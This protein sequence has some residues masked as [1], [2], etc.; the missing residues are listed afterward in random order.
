MQFHRVHGCFNLRGVTNSKGSG[1]KNLVELAGF[2][3][4]PM[5]WERLSV[6]GSAVVKNIGS[7]QSQSR[8]LPKE[9]NK[10]RVDNGIQPLI[11]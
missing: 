9:E 1:G 3:T 10:R 6:R 2:F 11:L 7:R 4:P 8:F 5:L